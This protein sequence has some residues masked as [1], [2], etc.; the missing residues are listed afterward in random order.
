MWNIFQIPNQ[1]DSAS[2]YITSTPRKLFARQNKK[3][4]HSL[5]LYIT[6]K[7]EDIF[8]QN[9]QILTECP[10]AVSLIYYFHAEECF[11]V[12]N[13]CKKHIGQNDR[14]RGQEYIGVFEENL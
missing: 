3:L 11:R 12:L 13:C 1:T 4:L 7:L 6:S 9:I 8:A 10:E 14:G 5:P 2:Q